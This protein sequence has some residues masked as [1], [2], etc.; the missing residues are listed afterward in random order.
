MVTQ[1]IVSNEK[2]QDPP[3]WQCRH[4]PPYFHGIYDEEEQTRGI[5]TDVVEIL[6]ALHFISISE[7]VKDRHVKIVKAD[8]KWVLEK[9][10]SWEAEKLVLSNFKTKFAHLSFKEL[11][12]IDEIEKRGEIVQDYGLDE[13]STVLEVKAAQSSLRLVIGKETKDEQSVY[14]QIERSSNEAKSIW[15]VSRTSLKSPMP[16][17][18]IGAFRPFSTNRFTP[19]MNYP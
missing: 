7:P 16:I 5:E 19:S 11:Y 10:F 9:P 1:G 15:K 14:V 13:N 2:D 4:R 8:E 3:S 18:L 17:L 6:S 12:S